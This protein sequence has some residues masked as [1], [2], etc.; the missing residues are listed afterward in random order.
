MFCTKKECRQIKKNLNKLSLEE[1]EI[2]F[3]YCNLCVNSQKINNKINVA[4]ESS[5]N[6]Q[7][8]YKY[9]WGDLN[10]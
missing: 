5:K 3:E 2:Q 4:M 8:R 7:Y 6:Y 9:L 1:L 10:A